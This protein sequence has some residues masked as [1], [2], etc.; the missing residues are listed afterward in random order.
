MII[1][2]PECGV[3]HRSQKGARS[4]YRDATLTASHLVIMG[5]IGT[6]RRKE[7]DKRSKRMQE[8]YDEL[9]T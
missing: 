9:P 2:C 4:C 5:E 6:N 3:K 8:Y 7:A 1:K